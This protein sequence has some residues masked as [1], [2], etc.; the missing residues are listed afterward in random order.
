MNITHPTKPVVLILAGHDPTG[1][2][3]IQADIETVTS[4]GV[5]AASIITSL[6]VQNT[7]TFSSHRP[8]REDDFIE[9]GQLIL[10]DMQ[11]SACK[12]GAIGHP[13]LIRA[14]HHMLTRQ[15]F[16]VVLD[17]VL[18]STT[19][20]TFADDEL[21]RQICSILLPLTTLVTPNRE[22][23]IQLTGENEPALAAK[24][25]LACGCRYVLVTDAEESTSEV[26]NHLYAKENDCQSYAWERLPGRYH[27][28]GCTL[29]SAITALLARG[30]DINTAVPLAQQYTWNTLKHGIQH[31]KGQ[32]HPDRFFWHHP[33]RKL[34]GK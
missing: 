33:D 8:Q 28:S 9:Q 12:I 14:I 19:G 6:T 11:I 21:G 16:P 23:A 5:C 25:L 10:A 26:I 17:P 3:G 15:N 2:A 20:H 34:F 32:L 18:R 13:S 22:E 24:K 7:Q 4:L 27:G 30:N 29:S 1:G 31:G